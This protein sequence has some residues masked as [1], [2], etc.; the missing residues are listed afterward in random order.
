MSSLELEVEHDGSF[1]TV[2][3]SGTELTISEAMPGMIVQIEKTA[4]IAGRIIRGTALDAAAYDA[5]ERG[6]QEE[7]RRR[8]TRR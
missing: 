2:D 6:I 8:Q 5:I 1:Y 4:I 7:I 3:V